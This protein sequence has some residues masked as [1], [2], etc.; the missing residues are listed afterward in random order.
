MSQKISSSILA[1][2]D[3]KGARWHVSEVPLLHGRTK[4]E[5]P[6]RLQDSSLRAGTQ[7]RD[8]HWELDPAGKVT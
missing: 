8:A 6:S 7:R 3:R 2:R 1:T 4:H 5:D